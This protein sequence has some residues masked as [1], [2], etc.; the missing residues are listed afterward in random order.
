MLRWWSFTVIYNKRR[1]KTVDTKT[2]VV[3]RWKI[4]YISWSAAGTRGGSG[5]GTWTCWAGGAPRHSRDKIICTVNITNCR[6]LNSTGWH[7]TT[8]SIVN[9]GDNIRAVGKIRETIARCFVGRLQFYLHR[10]G[11][12]H[13]GVP[14]CK[15]ESSFFWFSFVLFFIGR[16]RKT[17]GILILR[18]RGPI[19]Y[20]ISKRK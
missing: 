6:E 9:K 12:T 2:K 3:A 1:F 15:L 17:V 14:V 19:S 5:S 4:L 10:Q 7:R 11:S 13:I 20:S 8:A 18:T 16:R